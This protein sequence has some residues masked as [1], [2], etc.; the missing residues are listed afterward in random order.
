MTSRQ[1][2]GTRALGAALMIALSASTADAQVT[3]D[4]GVNW[5]GSYP[6]GVSDAD[7]RTNAP[8]SSPP[9][10][11]LFSVDSRIGAAVAGE[12]RVGVEVGKGFG[13][14]GTV[15]FARPRLAFSIS[16][17]SETSAGD[18]NGESLQ[19]YEF[20]AGLTW[21][22][23]RPRQERLRAFLSGGGA[24]LRDLHQ[25]RTL[26]E[27]GQLFYAGAG[28]RYWLRGRPGSP[29]SIG[30]RGDLRYNLRTGAIDFED[31]GRRYPSLSLLLFL[32]L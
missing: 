29:R 17:D 25:D 27:T 23:P 11:T 1:R 4:G 9:P 15:A 13:A 19:H 10:F 2:T 31:R 28:A 26:V 20:G 14:E 21:A 18:Y 24:Y 22:L 3:I 5:M 12:V 8:G 6:V 7:L 32:A 16:G 30:L